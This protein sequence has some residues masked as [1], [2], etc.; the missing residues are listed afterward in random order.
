MH[1]ILMGKKWKKLDCPLYTVVC[2]IEV[3]FKA[4]LSVL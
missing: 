4:G 1:Y 3:L 2:N